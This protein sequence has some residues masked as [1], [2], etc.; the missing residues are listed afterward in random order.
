VTS[1]RPASP[2]AIAIEN[3]PV[4]VMAYVSINFVVKIG[5]SRAPILLTIS[6]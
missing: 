5:Y 2:D 3:A 6:K 1:R 4:N